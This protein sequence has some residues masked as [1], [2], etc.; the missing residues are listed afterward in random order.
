RAR[1]LRPAP[2][3]DAK[4]SLPL[5]RAAIGAAVVAGLSLFA[6][7]AG[8]HDVSLSCSDF[9]V[10]GNGTVQAQIVFSQGE[11][12]LLASTGH[13]VGA[14]TAAGESSFDREAFRRS[15][16]DGVVVRADGRP[17]ERVA[18][19][20]DDGAADRFGV[21]LA[22]RCEP[23]QTRVDVELSFMRRLPAD[24]RHLLQVRDDTSSVSE[25]V[26]GPR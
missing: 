16:S 4:M 24:A 11:A 5:R 12:A 15:V 22:F 8:A 1:P 19:P 17:C 10:D 9:A 6:S 21:T 7:A 14:A 20:A 26:S 3:L 2:R 18:A 13:D 25:I 23:A